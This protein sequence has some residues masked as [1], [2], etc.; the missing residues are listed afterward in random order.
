MWVNTRS[1]AASL[2]AAATFALGFA[3][4]AQG[5]VPPAPPLPPAV[6]QSA[7]DLSVRR[8]G[9]LRFLG[10]S[11]YDGWLWSAAPGASFDEPLALDLHYHRS[12]AGHKIAE[13]SVDEIAKLGL[14]SVADRARWG[15]WMREMFPDV[16]KGDRLTGVY[17]PERGAQFFHNG[18]T[19][20]TTDD[21]AFARAFFAIWLDP[22]TSGPEFRLR[23]LG[24]K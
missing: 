15:A 17:L 16:A 21:V 6:V 12:L 10:L 19:L 7:P 14:G 20:G 2:A 3:M 11:I 9:E 8:G 5:R 4:P 1:F 22:R 13:R 18:R 24:E 23:L